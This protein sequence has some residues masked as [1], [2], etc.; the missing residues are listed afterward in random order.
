MRLLLPLIFSGIASAHVAARQASNCLT[1]AGVPQNAP[2]T[3]EFTQA[4]QGWNR[5]VQY[6]PVAIAAPTTVA[7]VQAAVSCARA[8]G[9]KVNPKSG[10]HGYA[11]HA[12]GGEN[13]HF[14]VDMKFMKD[15]TVN[16]TTFTAT[17]GAGARL[18]NLALALFNNGQ[19]AIAHGVCPG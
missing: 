8:A 14:I 15:I 3:P 12:I 7:Q 11:A 16:P 17:V 1:N 6:T 4:A 18:G 10:G 19:R 9:Y 2:G 13:G 5:R